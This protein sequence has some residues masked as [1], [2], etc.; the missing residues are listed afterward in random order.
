VQL[1]RHDLDTHW[2]QNRGPEIVLAIRRTHRLISYPDVVHYTNLSINNTV[3]QIKRN[4]LWPSSDTLFYCY[5]EYPFGL[6]MMKLL[7][8]TYWNI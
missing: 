7:Y 1:I 8:Y 5:S 6:M 3:D 4:S 2:L